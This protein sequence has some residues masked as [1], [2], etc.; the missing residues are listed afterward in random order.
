MKFTVESS[1]FAECMRKIQPAVGITKEKKEVTKNSVRL[2][3]TKKQKI[4][5]GY[6]GMAVSFDGKKQ[7]FSAFLINELEMEEEDYDA[8]ISGKKLCDITNAL[9]NGN[10]APLSLE[11]GKNCIIKKGGN[12][13]QIPL[14]EEPVIIPPTNDWLVRTTMDTKKFLE[15]LFKAGRFYDSGADGVTGSVCIHFDMENGKFQMSSTDTYKLAF[16]GDD[17]KYELS[18]AV[19]KEDPEQKKEL[20]YQVDGDQLK[21][22]TKFL[23]GKNT[24]VCAYE[25][26]LYFKSEA[27]IA[28]FMIK[29]AG[30]NPYALNGVLSMANGH[31]RASKITILPKDVLETLDVFDVANQGEEP[32]VYITKNKTGGL[33]FSTKAKTYKGIVPCKVEGKFKDMILNSKFFRM[34]LDNYDKEEAM[35]IYV[36]NSNESVLL[37][38]A[39]E[40]EDFNIIIRITE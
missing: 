10:D 5:E 23:T 24:E 35:N 12:Q 34:V 8:Y 4:K 19:K 31:S 36:G 29:D 28:M 18:D 15:I 39:E 14:G 37:K 27:D 30:E 2:T 1:R 13:V 21:I 9:N 25:K 16:Y 26:Y 32:F 3:M 17:V 38:E 11:V 7:L 6:I 33:C 20:I 40:T 22:L